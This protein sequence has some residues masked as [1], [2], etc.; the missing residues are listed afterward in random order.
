MPIRHG[1]RDGSASSLH[2]RWLLEDADYEDVI[3]SNMTL[4]RWGQIKGAFKLNNKLAL[5]GSGNEG[6]S[7]SAKYDLIF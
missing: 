5:L 7:P 1:A 4:P 6:Y 2:R 3:T